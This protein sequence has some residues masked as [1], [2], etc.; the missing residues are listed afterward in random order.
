MIRGGH[1]FSVVTF[2]D[3]PVF[4]QEDRFDAVLALN[5]ETARNYRTKLKKGGI[6][7]GGT[8]LTPSAETYRL[9]INEFIQKNKVSA[10]F[11]NNLLLGALL[12]RFGLSPVGLDKVLREEF[13]PAKRKTLLAAIRAG[14]SYP[15][16]S[17]KIILGGKA[18]IF[19]NGSQAV[20]RAAITSGADTFFFYPMTPA[21]GVFDEIGLLSKKKGEKIA[22]V[23][24]EDEIASISAALGASYA[25]AKILVGTSGGGLDLMGEAISLAGMAEIPAVI[26]LAQRLGPS[27]GVPTYTSQGDLELV[28]N[29]G[30]GEFPR[31]VVVPGDARE[32]FLRTNEAF[33]L[34]HKYRI[35]AFVVSDKHLAESYYS[36][37]SP[38]WP[39][40]FKP[41]VTKNGIS[42]AA[43][44]GGSRIAR[45]NSYEHD[46]EGFTVEDAAAI[47]RMNR[48]RMKKNEFLEKETEKFAPVSFYGRGK[49]LIIS[50][51]STKGAILDAL[52]ELRD[53]RFMQISYLS[54]FP[55]RKVSDEI[56]RAE[57]VW[58]VE[59]NLTS[60]LG[61]IIRE[62][63][64]I[65][66]DKKILKADGRP[67]LAG[68]IVRSVRSA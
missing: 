3:K 17:R 39:K 63:T 1:N 51:G 7:I 24:L 14:Y 20:A 68:E 66:I 32:A 25:G 33:Y 45:V 53:F 44:P 2:S 30:H 29:I 28:L 21:T 41:K 43:V 60:L 19:L 6:I 37:P 52:R 49:R 22:L 67:F 64:G 23:N 54:P 27:T 35:P 57:A 48:K 18:K 31:L 38:E 8:E 56:R 34:A 40:V 42:P 26:Y 55:A 5:P 15:V 9:E 62:N 59:N 11:G 36:F 47:L 16:K 58:L 13:G 12:K 50:C 61:R 46:E 10:V 4:S 65:K